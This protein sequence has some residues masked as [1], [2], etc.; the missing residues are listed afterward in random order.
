M[1][2][3]RRLQLNGSPAVILA[4]DKAVTAHLVPMQP[5]YGE[6]KARSRRLFLGDWFKNQGQRSRLIF[7]GGYI[8]GRID[9]LKPGEAR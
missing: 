5:K 9:C 4:D 2:A 3:T 1:S 8:A 7:R 6:A